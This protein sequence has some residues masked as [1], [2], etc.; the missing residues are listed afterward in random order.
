MT[1]LE[2]QRL[3]RKLYRNSGQLVAA[4][5]REGKLGGING[6]RLGDKRGGGRLPFG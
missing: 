5:V 6:E 4:G 3:R 1:T 2:K